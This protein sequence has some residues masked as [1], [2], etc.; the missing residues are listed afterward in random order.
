M[1]KLFLAISLF[2]T[3]SVFGIT[4][5]I[6]NATPGAVQIQLDLRMAQD[7][8]IPLQPGEM[9]KISVGV[10]P[11]RS[12][13]VKVLTGPLAGQKVTQP[14]FYCLPWGRKLIIGMHNGE[15]AIW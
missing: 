1:K 3:G 11:L 6:V 12:V 4:H 10:F 13:T 5:T 14:I 2:L 7:M 15:V 9:Q 8:Y